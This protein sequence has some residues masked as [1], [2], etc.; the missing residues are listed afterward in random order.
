MNFTRII[1]G[2]NQARGIPRNRTTTVVLGLVGCCILPVLFFAASMAYAQNTNATIRGQVLDPSG[3]AVPDAQ[4]LIVGQQTGVTVFTGKSDSV[5][6][7]VAPQVIPGTYRITV[8]AQGFRQSVVSNLVA[9]VAQVTQVNI[10]LQMGQSNQTITVESKGE[11]LDRGTSNVS[12]LVTPSEVQDLPLQRRDT[13]NLLASVPGVAYGG[14]ANTP[15]TSQLSING[16]RTLNTEV[17]LNG[18]ST[19]IASTGTPA[20]LPS[21]DG[22]D[23]FRAL[24]TNAPAEYGRTS[25]AVISVNTISGTNAYHG[26][27]YFLMRNEALDANSYF[28][29]RTPDPNHPGAFLPRGRDRFFQEGG[30]IGGPVRIPHVYD[31]HKKTFFF[32]NY[33]R[34][35]RPSSSVLTFTV[36]TAAQRAGDLSAALAPFDINGKP[37]TP[38]RIFQPT[39]TSSPAFVNN[40][41]GPIDPAAA[42]ILTL[43]PLPNAPGTYDPVNN[44]FTGNWVSQQNNTGHVAK[45]VG[46]LDEQL[47]TNDRLSI[48]VYRFM[49]ETPNPVS[50]N[51]TLLNTTWDCTCNNA[52][53]PSMNYTRVWNPTLVMDLNFGFFRNVVLRNPPGAGMN[54]AQ[55][56]GI[57]SLPLD[58]T[59]QMTSPGFSNIGAD[60]NTNQVNI[61]NTFTEFGTVSKTAGPHTFK[62]G[63]SLRKNQFN[64][65]NPSASPEGT[66]SFD[67][68]TTNHGNAGNANTGIADFLLGK[69]KTANYQLP[70]PKT[71]R[72]NFNAGVFFQDDWRVTPKLTLNL[73][74]RYEYESPMVIANNVYSR[75]DPVTGNL[76]VADKNGTSRSLNIRTPKLDFSPR[77]GLAY[78][79]TDKTIFRAAFGTFYGTI[80]QNLGGQ[81]A[82]PGYDVTGNFPNL[83]TAIAQPFSLSQGFPLIAVQ[84]LSNPFAALANA[85][86]ANPFTGAGTSFNDLSHIPLVEQWNVG[87]Q[88]ELP[89]ALTFEVNYVGNIARHLAYNI[90]QNNVPLSQVDA[91][92]LANN[93]VTTQL[94]RPFPQLGT[95]A[96]VDDFGRSSYNSLQV[97]VRRRFQK[98]FAITAN[99]TFAKSLDDGSTI[100]NFSAPN[101]TANAQYT[102]DA[103]HRA[104]DR[105]VSSIDVKHTMR[106]A[107]T[108]TTPG[109]WWLRDWHV[110]SVFVGHTGLPVNITQTNEIPGVSNQR[111]NGDPSHLK[112]AHAT[113]NTGSTFVQYLMPAIDPNFPLTPSGPVYATIGGVRTRIVPTGFGN[114]PRDALRAPGEVN[115]DASVSK[116]FHLAEGLRFQFRM[117]AFNVFNHTNFLAPNT[118]LTV[119]TVGGV[120]SLNQSQNFGRITGA[121]PARTMQASAR[122]F[123]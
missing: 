51:S 103:A 97:S 40:Q 85:S 48:N 49:T 115:F 112:L 2:L 66:M 42:K 69:I 83:G 28:N 7:F 38:Q 1:R 92:T 5:G 96:N 71:G 37:R 20:T 73:G 54:A 39:G 59:P 120:A 35:V 8:T 62:A 121:Q 12:T 41:V 4:V 105:A 15:S 33:D 110:S 57:A 123:F 50:W 119:T 74:V 26:S 24:T 98:H 72:R 104:A 47:T 102:G 22:V 107:L 64:S 67:G 90:G 109:P 55:Q 114:V 52:W 29:K 95:F 65:F 44:R 36:P 89:F 27:L 99:Y 60:T 78:A 122:F 31:G 9:A 14:A 23:S 25:G 87:F 81:I 56:L 16:G 46:R 100:Y 118:A 91:V 86:P 116:D 82:Y 75:F 10:T 80:F 21:P 94:A 6:T 77:I 34:T 106:V 30:A 88:R 11:E 45:I 84:N 117:D 58:Q 76:L 79:I 17:L 13:E 63:A 108:Y 68:S 101:G 111:P 43:L 93:P 53:L 70:M 19:I 18:V 113:V 3:A 32:F 61:T